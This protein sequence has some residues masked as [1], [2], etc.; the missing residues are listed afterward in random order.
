MILVLKWLVWLD[1]FTVLNDFGIEIAGLA[2]PS[3]RFP[4]EDILKSMACLHFSNQLKD[5]ET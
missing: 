4:I 3:H 1:P 5:V 2:G